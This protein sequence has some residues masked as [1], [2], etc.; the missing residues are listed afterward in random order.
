MRAVFGLAGAPIEFTPKTDA[1]P[2]NVLL[3]VGTLRVAARA[4]SIS[5]FGVGESPTLEVVLNNN[6]KQTTPIIGN[7]LRIPV[8]VTYDDGAPFFAG[9][10]SKVQF[11][12]TIIVTLGN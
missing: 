5:G 6:E 11:G 7:P 3:A 10:V 4:G 8:S 12:R 9:V 2:Y 1:G